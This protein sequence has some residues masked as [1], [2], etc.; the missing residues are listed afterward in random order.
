MMLTDTLSKDTLFVTGV[1]IIRDLL[2]VAVD[3]RNTCRITELI[4][5]VANFCREEC[6]GKKIIGRLTKNF[7]ILSKLS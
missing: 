1:S 7:S 6:E 2:T 3:L 5:D 4:E